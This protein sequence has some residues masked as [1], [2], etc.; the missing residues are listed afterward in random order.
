M[1]TERAVKTGSAVKSLIATTTALVVLG[2]CGGGPS[3]QEVLED[4]GTTE[5]EPT[6]ETF[7][8]TTSA[9]DDATAALCAAP[10]EAGLDAARDALA[11]T[12][13]IWSYSEAMW[14]GPVME[15]RSWALIDW[16][17]ADDEIEA[18]LADPSVELDT[19]LLAKGIGA[20][21]RGLQTVEYLLGAPDDPSALD[22]LGDERRCTYL[23]GLAT[24]IADEAAAIE[25]AWT[26]EY[27]DGAP[28]VDL[29]GDESTE[30][31]D[32]IVNDALYLLES[33]TDLELAKALGLSG[34]ADLDAIEE[35]PLGLGAEDLARHLA[36]L[37][38]VFVGTSG[39]GGLAPL[40]GDD[41]ASRLAGELDAAEAAVAAIEGPLIPRIDEA[42][43][44]VEA[45]REAIKVV[46]VTV[47]TEVVSRLGVT[48]GFSDADG[49]SG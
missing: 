37:R 46:Q 30:A 34:D 26:V 3:R 31:L 22:A 21:Q 49:D 14:V 38:A 39:E 35:G 9:L 7:A 27:E 12:R 45:A 24:V 28:F 13:S 44:E 5:I 41:L 6:Y 1:T 16:P 40:L 17:I 2:G 10:D 11:A 20:D 4:L 19:E 48:V 8:Q 15:R 18:L 43:A 36:G 23:T 42:P 25:A 29:V 47:G 33:M 32:M